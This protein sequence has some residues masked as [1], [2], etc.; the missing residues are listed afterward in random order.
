MR[1]ESRSPS[2]GRKSRSGSKKRADDSPPQYNSPRQKLYEAKFEK[3]LANKEQK[4]KQHKKLEK[5][6]KEDFEIYMRGPESP[7]K[8]SK[9]FHSKERGGKYEPE[10]LLP[11]DYDQQ[12]INKKL[13]EDKHTNAY[14]NSKDPFKRLGVSNEDKMTFFLLKWIFNAVKRD[15]ALEDTKLQGKPYITKVDLVKQ[16]AK[17]DELMNAL[18]YEGPEQ[19]T[20]GV[21]KMATAKDGC[22]LWEE[23]LDFFFLR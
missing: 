5:M 3:Y 6:K 21:K 10:S 13:E 22:M 18:G 20:S 7:S 1:A 11:A 8:S 9:R 16:L 2:R 4:Q 19:I 17:N 12:L 23:F 15:S 14:S